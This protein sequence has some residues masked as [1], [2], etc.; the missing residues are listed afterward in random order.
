MVHWR[1]ISLNLNLK[2]LGQE[3]LLKWFFFFFQTSNGIAHSLTVE[4]KEIYLIYSSVTI[5]TL[6]LINI[7]SHGWN[8]LAASEADLKNI[9]TFSNSVCF[10]FNLCYISSMA[11]M[12]W[13]HSKYAI[14]LH[15]F[16]NWVINLWNLKVCFFKFP[17][18]SVPAYFKSHIA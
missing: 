13:L 7:H 8:F 14:I 15:Y 9:E 6:Q 11:E 17:D 16:K 12:A 4:E 10:S 2:K 18:V 5:T 3:W 1:A